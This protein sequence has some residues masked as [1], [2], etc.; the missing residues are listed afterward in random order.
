MVM[1][2][3]LVRFY[4]YPGESVSIKGL[5]LAHQLHK[6]GTT[7]LPFVYANFLSSLDGRIAL[8]DTVQGTYIPKHI[9]TASDFGLFMELHAQADCL[10]THGGYMRAL[11]EG[12]LGNILQV[13]DKGLVEWRQNN[14]LKPQPTV[15]IASAS[16]DFP[17]H[18]SL[19]EHAQAVY[20]A[21]GRNADSERIRYWQDLGVPLLFTGED[22]MVQ[23]APLIHQLSGL[24]YK[25]IYLIAGPQMLDT[26]IRD[27][28]LSRLY[29]TITHQLIGGKDFRTLLTG[30]I[31]GSEGDLILEALYYEQDSPPGSGQ[32]FIQFGLNR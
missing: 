14:G 8:E 16:L 11:G 5:Y 1:Q 32:F 2:K 19:R 12:R 9:T 15:I 6:Q 18:N 25:T 23:G 13:R 7:E 20:I 21:T 17:L 28:Q 24:G 10:I 4:P 31:L 30:S 27:K 3:K 22:R 29:L 26:I